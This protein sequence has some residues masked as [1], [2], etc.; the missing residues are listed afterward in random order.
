MEPRHHPLA[1]GA[2]PDLLGLQQKE[3][4]NLEAFTHSLATEAYQDPRGRITRLNTGKGSMGKLLTHP[5]LYRDTAE[6]PPSCGN[7][8]PTWRRQGLI[9]TLLNDKA[10]KDQAVKTLAEMQGTFANLNKTTADERSGGPAARHGEETGEFHG[11]PGPGL[12]RV[13]QE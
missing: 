3:I 5:A 11:E 4:N 9:G 7:S 6:P 12:A 10:F 8:S 13:C 2:R 1:V